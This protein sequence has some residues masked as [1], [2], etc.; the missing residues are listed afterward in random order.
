[1]KFFNAKKI[2]PFFSKGILISLLL[3]L[4]PSLIIILLTPIKFQKYLVE[5]E[6]KIPR[7]FERINWY[8]DLDVDGKEEFMVISNHQGASMALQIFDSEG[9]HLGQYNLSYFMPKTTVFLEPFFIDLNK[10]NVKEILLFSQNKDSVY[11]NI[12]DY[13][14]LEF[15]LS[16]RFITKIGLLPNSKLDYRI[17]WID[18]RDINNDS[19][20]EIYFAIIT[21]FGLYPRNVF[22]YDFSNDSLISSPNIGAQVGTFQFSNSTLFVG[23]QASANCRPDFPYP[24]TDTCTWIFG[25]NENLEYTFKPISF[26]GYPASIPSITKTKEGIAAMYQNQGITGDTTQLV[27]VK[28]KGEI[29][30]RKQIVSSQ[31]KP[32]NI[33]G[34]NQYLIMNRGNPNLYYFNNEKGTIGKEIKQLKNCVY[35]H[36]K[37]IDHDGEIEH[38]FYNYN[39]QQLIIARNDL[40]EHIAIDLDLRKEF[41]RAVTSGL[42]EAYVEIIVHTD[43]NVL[44]YKYY[45]NPNYQYKYLF[46]FVVYLLSFVFIRAILHIQKKQIQK[47]SRLEKRIIQLQLKNTQNHLNPHFTFNALNTVSKYIFKEDKYKAYDLFERFARLMRSSLVFS[48]KIFRSLEEELQFT[49][50]YLEFQKSRFKERFDY[51]I[52][53]ADNIGKAIIQIPKML[54]QGFAENAVKHAFIGIDYKGILEINIEKSEDKTL[55]T[56]E[57]N[58]IGINASKKENPIPKSGYGMHILEEQIALIN[59]L[60]EQKITYEVVDKSLLDRNLSGTKVVLKIAGSSQQAKA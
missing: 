9:E 7:T 41:F 8:N 49:E 46:W 31:I 38:F 6:K 30:K 53:V 23:S 12:F 16:N 29:T 14:K 28:Q 36:S 58:G 50:D 19:I 27:F 13:K 1:M 18:A 40:Q 55:I 42:K 26:A 11:L 56:I 43:L 32:I 20:N 10:D 3:S 60:Y 15:I 2:V 47:K 22:R 48:D 39:F 59:K 35:R 4:V 21:G 33:K 25:F 52:S 17:K 45:K 51:E 54:I 57:D 24:Y 37:D 44:F 5:F 34:E